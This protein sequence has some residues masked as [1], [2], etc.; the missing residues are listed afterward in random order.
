VISK[1]V[2]GIPAYNEEK[3]IALVV[4]RALDY[5]SSVVVVDDGSTDQTTAEALRAGATVIRH[6]VN[7]GKGVAVA[8]LFEF[9]IKN[10]AQVLVLIDG[11]G[12]HDPAEIQ[13]LAEKCLAGEA[14][15]VVGSRFIA[16]APSTTPKIRRWGQRAFNAMTAIASGIYCSDS[17]SGFRAFNRRAFCAMRLTESSF[18]VESEM[19]FEFRAKGLRLAEVPI[20]CSYA[21]PPKRNVLSH[22]RIVLAGLLRMAVERRALGQAP[23]GALPSTPRMV[24]LAERKDVPALETVLVTTTHGD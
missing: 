17:Q 1:L 5:S 10:E 13:N 12:Q 6:P 24:V 18:S 23:R 8:T 4:A 22:G 19:Q 11:D 7:S 21:E 20:S 15:V 9:A 3:C 14:D 16:K 2:V